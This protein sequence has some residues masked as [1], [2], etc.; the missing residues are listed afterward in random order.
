[1]SGVCNAILAVGDVAEVDVKRAK[2]AF[3]PSLLE[4]GSFNDPESYIWS[5][6]KD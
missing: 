1:M 3:V 4:D 2:C 6:L 5:V